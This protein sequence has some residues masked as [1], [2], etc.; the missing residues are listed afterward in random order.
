V[1]NLCFHQNFSDFV[2]L[3]RI[4]EAKSLLVRDGGKKNI[5]DILLEAGFN[6]KSSF[7]TIFKEKTGMSPSQYRRSLQR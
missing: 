7:N 5:L 6:S 2:N 4:E 1:I 3:L